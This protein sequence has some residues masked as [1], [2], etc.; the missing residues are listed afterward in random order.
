MSSNTGN[1]FDITVFQNCKIEES[2][3][4]G[5]KFVKFTALVSIRP[6][7]TAN[8]HEH[9]LYLFKS[10]PEEPIQDEYDYYNF[11]IT[12]ENKDKYYDSK[13]KISEEFWKTESY[14]RSTTI[15]PFNT[16]DFEDYDAGI[17]QDL[18][19]LKLLKDYRLNDNLGSFTPFLIQNAHFVGVNE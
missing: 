12:I 10:D 1:K 15:I 4:G 16:E 14:E 13:G 17:K 18:T 8:L 7:A 19:T 11:I 5:V 3:W 9:P 2:F 6:T